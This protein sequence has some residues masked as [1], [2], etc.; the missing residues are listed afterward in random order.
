MGGDGYTGCREFEHYT[1][2][3]ESKGKEKEITFG[4]LSKAREFYDSLNVGKAIW[5]L[6]GLEL[7]ECHAWGTDSPQNDELP[8]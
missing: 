4:Q 1:V 3:Y 8:F 6:L 5:R 2:K 7:L